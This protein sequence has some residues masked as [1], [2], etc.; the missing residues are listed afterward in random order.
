MQQ[1]RVGKAKQRKAEQS[2]GAEYSN[3]Q[4][5]LFFSH[6]CEKVKRVTRTCLRLVYHQGSCAIA[7]CDIR[8][9]ACNSLVFVM[10]IFFLEGT[11]VFPSSRARN[12]QQMCSRE[13]EVE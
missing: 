8:L 3:D 6:G 11:C 13:A 12:H 10:L 7:S 4:E 2:K 1:E 9:A 5:V